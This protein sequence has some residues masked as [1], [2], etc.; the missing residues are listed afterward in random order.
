MVSGNLK[1]IYG[2]EIG[3]I[4]GVNKRKSVIEVYL[5]KISK[6]QEKNQKT[7][8]EYESIYWINTLKEIM[9]KEF[10]IRSGK[11]VRKDSKTIIDEEYGFMHCKVD[12]RIVG[13]NSILMC[14]LCNG[15][16]SYEVLDKSILLECQH[17]MRVTKAD[18]CYIAYLINDEKFIFKEV[19]RDENLISK[20]IKKEKS[21]MINHILKEIPP[22]E[23]S[24][25]NNL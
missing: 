14:I 23:L 7:H 5:D 13:E 8:E 15:T 12:R 20:I 10:T 25:N 9:C 16:N 6:E 19:C 22:K 4:L 18:K 2:D 1:G 21:F 11:K 17:N 3:S 24:F